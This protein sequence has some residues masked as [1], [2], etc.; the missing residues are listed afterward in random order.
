MNIQKKRGRPHNPSKE[1]MDARPRILNRQKEAL[2]QVTGLN[3]NKAA[4]IAIDYFLDN[5]GSYSETRK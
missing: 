4:R 1:P 3:Y 2:E 5:A